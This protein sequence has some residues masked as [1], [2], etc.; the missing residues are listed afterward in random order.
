MMEKQRE[1]EARKAFEQGVY[2]EYTHAC[3]KF[4]EKVKNVRTMAGKKKSWR[5][6]KMPGKERR[7]GRKRCS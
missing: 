2:D 5:R 1:K 4:S 3:H 7:K 6:F